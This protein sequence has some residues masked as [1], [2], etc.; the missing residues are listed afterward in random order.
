MV[1]NPIYEGAGAIYEEIPGEKN[2]RS[3][4]SKQNPVFSEFEAGEDAYVSIGS[5][6]R[7]RDVDFPTLDDVRG[8]GQK[9]LITL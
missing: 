7:S 5:R 9:K 8:F 2:L 4:P 6:T 3:V 1:P